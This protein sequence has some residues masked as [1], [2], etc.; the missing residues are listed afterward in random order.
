MASRSFSLSTL[1]QYAFLAVIGYVLAGAPL[2]S[3]FA[4]SKEGSSR[5]RGVGEGRGKGRGIKISQ[6]KL[7]SLVVP[8][9][10]LSCAAHEY[11]GVHVL[12]REPL[13]VYIEG[14]LGDGEVE[15]VVELR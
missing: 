3:I 5:G 1:A 14:F 15:E 2:L 7:E 6:E 9:G 13:V 11:R 10:N 8:E 12:N 4:D